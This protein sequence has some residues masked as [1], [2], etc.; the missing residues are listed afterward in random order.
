MATITS[1][2]T[3]DWASTSTWVGGSV[4]ITGTRTGDVTIDGNLH[5]AD[6][7]KMHLHGRMTVKNT[8]HSSD[9]TGEFVEG[10]TASGSLLSMVGGT[11]IKISGSNSDQH[12]IQVDTRKWCGVD[13]QGGEPTLITKLNGNLDY[14]SEYMTVDSA[15]NFAQGDK[16]SLYEREVDWE[17]I[18]DECFIVHDTD[19]PNNRIYF[20]QY[21][22][23]T[24]V[25]SSSSGST[26]T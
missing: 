4:P 15:A 19:V 26:I 8:S 16:I 1:N 5:F 20:R 12:G 17:A 21:V 2:Q 3:G 9:N 18:V 7:G 10:T 25:I 23:P 22:T 6:G 13:I 14:N 24:A 11:E